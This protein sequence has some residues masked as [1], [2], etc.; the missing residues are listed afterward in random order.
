MLVITKQGNFMNCR[1]CKRWAWT[2]VVLCISLLAL[3]ITNAYHVRQWQEAI[4]HPRDMT[5]NISKALDACTKDNPNYGC[6]I[7][8]TNGDYLVRSQ[9]PFREPPK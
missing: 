8:F 4:K 5:P 9:I 7:I 3:A 1:R 6:V 2:C